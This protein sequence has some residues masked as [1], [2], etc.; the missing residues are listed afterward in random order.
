MRKIKFLRNHGDYKRHQVIE[1]SNNVAHGL[2][3]K[4]VAKVNKAFKGYRN[5]QIRSYRNKC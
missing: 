2:I 3:D 1:V 5:K 4:G